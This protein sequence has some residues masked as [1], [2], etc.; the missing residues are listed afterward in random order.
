MASKDETKMGVQ[1]KRAQ[2]SFPA[3]RRS[4]T[5]DAGG[6][7]QHKYDWDKVLP[8]ILGYLTDGTPP[9]LAVAAR[10][11]GVDAVT[12]QTWMHT[13]MLKDH[14]QLRPWALR[15][16]QVQGDFAAECTKTLMDPDI[17]GAHAK[18]LHWILERISREDFQLPKQIAEVVPYEAPRTL[19]LDEAEQVPVDLEKYLSAPSDEST[20]Q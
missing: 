1:R 14:A 7:F 15:V 6:K 13:G 5:H 20:I 12:A 17:S 11:A 19:E 4:Q 18:N 3:M 9:F 16:K 8:A 2:E 10:R